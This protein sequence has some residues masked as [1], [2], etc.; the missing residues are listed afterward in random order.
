MKICIAGKNDIAVNALYYVINEYDADNVIVVLNRNDSGKDDWQKSLKNA[1][2][3]LNIKTCSLEDIYK[4]SDLYFFSLEFDKIVKTEK[5]KTDKL[6]NIHFSNL[7]K[8]KGM[9]TSILPILNG[10]NETGVTLHKIDNGIDTGDIIAQ[11]NSHIGI[12]DTSRDVYFKFLENAFILFKE[13]FA[14]ILSNAYSSK[15]QPQV[16]SSYY[17]KGTLDF[18]NIKI[19]FNKTSFEIHNQLRAFMFKEYQLPEING[20]KVEKSIL[21]DSFIG[22]NCFKEKESEF[23]ISGIDGYKI[24]VQK[25]KLAGEM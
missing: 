17:S 1:A 9:Y 23:I 18:K 21:T 7:P 10:E 3:E 11:K 5:F 14:K 19:D 2:N 6:F 22:Y 12:K 4:I 25:Q 24:S 16:N 20:I 8:Y 13:N 15:K